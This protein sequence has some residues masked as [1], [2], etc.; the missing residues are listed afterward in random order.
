[1]SC[2]GLGL[3]HLLT[4]VLYRAGR[5]SSDRWFK[6]DEA[7][8]RAIQSATCNRPFTSSPGIQAYEF[9]SPGTNV[10]MLGSLT[11]G[12]CLAKQHPS[13][14]PA[15]AGSGPTRRVLQRVLR[16]LAIGPNVVSERRSIDR[17]EIS[18]LLFHSIERRLG[19]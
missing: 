4:C 18:D 15:G 13:S 19:P 11:A 6:P 17:I 3:D 12:S 14:Q 7:M 1:M 5:W 9:R 2:R 10:L 8:I 16:A